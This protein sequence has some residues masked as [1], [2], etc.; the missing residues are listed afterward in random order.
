MPHLVQGC[1]DTTRPDINHRGV[2]STLL[3]KDLSRSGAQRPVAPFGQQCDAPLENR[4]LSAGWPEKDDVQRRVKIADR[5]PI[6]EGRARH[7]RDR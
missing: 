2:E 7:L 3:R 5:R 4:A 6:E 1:V